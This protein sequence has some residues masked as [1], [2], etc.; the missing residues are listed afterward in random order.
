[1]T[2]GQ[3]GAIFGLLVAGL[4]ISQVANILG[5][6]TATVR[7]QITADWVPQIRHR[8]GRKKRL[9]ALAP[10]RAPIDKQA[11]I[12]M[13]DNG[14]LTL[15]EVGD[16]FGVTR[17]RI[18]QILARQGLTERNNGALAPEVLAS[19]LNR[20]LKA[21]RPG[22]SSKEACEIA[23]LHYGEVATAAR[24]LGYTL[25]KPTRKE[26]LMYQEIAT[27]Y[28]ANPHLTGR[29][30]AVH[31][32]VPPLTVSRALQK[33]GVKPRHSGWRWRHPNHRHK[34]GLIQRDTRNGETR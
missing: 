27:Y 31:F 13:H 16:H 6:A 20:Y 28:E 17:E 11:V 24:V 32:G 5:M 2:K 8:H 23:E 33:L 29:A 4:S 19:R 10:G 12:A 7:N 14:R 25:P 30:V 26:R 9:G 34:S 18:R 21:L 1:M 22:V 15:Q 3:R